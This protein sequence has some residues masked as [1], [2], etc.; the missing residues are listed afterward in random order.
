MGQRKANMILIALVSV[1]H[2]QMVMNTRKNI[3]NL[4]LTKN[5][6]MSIEQKQKKG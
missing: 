3:P 1:K 4:N 5:V 6:S 2:L